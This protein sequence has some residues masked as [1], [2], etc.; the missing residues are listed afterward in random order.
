MTNSKPARR[1]LNVKG[2]AS[3]VSLAKP[4][5]PGRHEYHCR[6]CSHS[7]RDEIEQAF[8]TWNSPVRISKEYGVSRDSVYRHAHALGLMAKR[9]RNVSSALERIIE[10]AGEV[11]AS[12]AAV[13]SAVAAY[14]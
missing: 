1:N 14:A 4:T 2:N 11:E 8:V 10:Q 5:N 3:A 12:A 7:E 13:V 6:I 9:R